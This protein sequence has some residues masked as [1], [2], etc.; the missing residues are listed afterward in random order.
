MVARVPSTLDAHGMIVAHPV[1]LTYAT[2]EMVRRFPS[3]GWWWLEELNTSPN[4]HWC[5]SK[6]TS[7]IRWPNDQPRPW[8]QAKKYQ[9]NVAKQEKNACYDRGSSSSSFRL[10]WF[11]NGGGSLTQSRRKMTILFAWFSLCTYPGHGI[12]HPVEEVLFFVQ[13]YFLGRGLELPSWGTSEKNGAHLCPST[14][15]DITSILG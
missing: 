15:H 7:P 3:K 11:L 1:K 5:W 13:N 10:K 9:I 14:R 4:T 12:L 2:V 6:L 8:P